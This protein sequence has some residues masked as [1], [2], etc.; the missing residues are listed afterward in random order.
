[1]GSFFDS[2][3]PLSLIGDVISAGASLI[4]G[5]K[6][7]QTIKSEGGA[8]REYE[9]AQRKTFIQDRVADAEAAGIHPL[10]ALGANAPATN[11]VRIATGKGKA[12]ADAG[13]NIGNA[14][15]RM[16]DPTSRAK[17][18]AEIALIEASTKKEESLAKYYNSQSGAQVPGIGP[19]RETPTGTVTIGQMSEVIDGQMPNS[20]GVGILEMT[21][22]Q[23]KTHKYGKPGVQTGQNPAYQEYIMPGGQ[24]IL[25]PAGEQGSYAEVWEQI[26]FWQIPGILQYN[27]KFYGDP[28]LND[29]R[30]FT[31]YGKTSKHGYPRAKSRRQNRMFKKERR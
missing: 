3:N 2:F 25:L 5:N 10:Y 9:A 6:Q 21:P 8:Q 1:M 15:S 27:S 22:P 24:P 13:Q 16:L 17:A 28:W 23:V 7:A 11:P 29:F 26:P 18:A 12:L 14:V 4:G 31:V 20:P 19:A 30:D